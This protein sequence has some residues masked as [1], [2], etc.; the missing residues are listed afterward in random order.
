[1]EVDTDLRD[2]VS[3]TPSHCFKDGTPK[4]NHAFGD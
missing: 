4:E 1:M 2:D 3:P